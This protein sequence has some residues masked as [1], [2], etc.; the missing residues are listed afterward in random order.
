MDFD[1]AINAHIAWKKK[2]GTYLQNPDKSLKAAE[3]QVD[4]KCDLG[5]WIYGEGAKHAALPEYSVLK[6][7]HAKF[8][9]CAASIII[10]ADAG[11]SVTEEVALGSKSEFSVASA[12]VVGAIMKM[13][14]HG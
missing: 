8:H 7:E 6:T 2:L 5:K 11:K 10:Q 3:V 13:R 9:K 1:A 14:R 12:N 4:N